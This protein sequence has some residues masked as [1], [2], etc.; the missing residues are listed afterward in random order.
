MED[1]DFVGGRTQSLLI[2]I[3]S[4]QMRWRTGLC[5]PAEVLV[6]HGSAQPAGGDPG[7]N[8]MDNER[9]EII[10]ET[11]KRLPKSPWLVLLGRDR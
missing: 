10:A 7:K 6:E 5:G 11:L 1:E 4:A 8:H 9:K 3:G 2:I